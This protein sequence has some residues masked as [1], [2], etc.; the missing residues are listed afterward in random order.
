MT[1]GFSALRLRTLRSTDVLQAMKPKEKKKGKK[2]GLPIIFLT[3][4]CAFYLLAV[5]ISFGLPT[6]L[7]TTLFKM[8]LHV[9]ALSIKESELIDSSRKD[10]S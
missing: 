4:L 7:Q 8:S 9:S 10:K 3:T 2:K 6:I 1:I 5:G